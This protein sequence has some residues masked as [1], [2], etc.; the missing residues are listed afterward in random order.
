MAYG[1][2]TPSQPGEGV[3][4]SSEERVSLMEA[5]SDVGEVQSSTYPRR[6]LVPM[7]VV[8][9]C[10]LAGVSGV[11]AVSLKKRAENQYTYQAL[12]E[13]LDDPDELIK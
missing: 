13:Q 9:L 4:T 7:A 12:W 5:E 6:K 10:G 11:V 8:A 3:H 2:T 1:S